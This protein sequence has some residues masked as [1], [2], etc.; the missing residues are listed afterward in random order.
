MQLYLETQ[1]AYPKINLFAVK[2][3][4]ENFHPAFLY[5]LFSTCSFAYSS[6]FISLLQVCTTE[7]E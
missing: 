6:L 7:E 2:C 3:K 4:N 1:I 5:S